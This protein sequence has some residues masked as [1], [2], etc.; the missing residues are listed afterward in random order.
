MIGERIRL[1]REACRLTQQNLADRSGVPLGTLSA[2]EAGRV[3]E[4]SM[5][6]IEGV[7]AATGFPVPF[8]QLGPLP[9]LPEGYFRKLRRGQAK[10]T[11]QFRAQVRQLVELV[12]RAEAHLRL[13]PVKIEPARG[14]FSFEEIESVAE[15]T[16]HDLGIGARDPIPNLTRAL[17]RS[18]V[19]V[20]R[21]PVAI[22]DHDGYSAWPEPGLDGRP[23][24]AIAAGRSGDRDRANLGHELGHLKL[25]TMR[26]VDPERAEKEAWRFASA[27]LLPK[28][29]AEEAMRPPVTLRV[30]MHVKAT[31]GTSIALNAKRALDLGL[32]TNTQF[33]SFR[34]QMSSRGWIKEE[35]VEVAQEKP[36]LLP[37]IVNRMAGEGSPT[38]RASRVCLPLFTLRAVTS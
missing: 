38:Q 20:V 9:D 22:V 18:G 15:E 3:A 10:D 23:I 28:E 32:V 26:S 34:K 7:A 29:A 14:D 17:E 37:S 13:P 24:I 5:A 36:A 35:P 11:K 27:L 8:F 12:Q 21:L 30:L 19:I 1:A 25:H 16:R 2:I 33:V 4:P 31:F 6:T